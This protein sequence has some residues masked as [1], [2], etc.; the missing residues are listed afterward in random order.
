MIMDVANILVMLRG[1]ID[2]KVPLM[3]S[4]SG[5]GVRDR[6]L[7]YSMNPADRSALERALDISKTGSAKVIVCAYDAPYSEKLLREALAMGADRATLLQ[8]LSGTGS[9]AMVVAKILTRL[10]ELLKIDL[11]CTGTRLID[12]GAALEP[13]VA[14][15]LLGRCCVH[16]VVDVDIVGKTIVAVKKSDRGGRQEVQAELPAFLLFEERDESIYP[17]VA[18]LLE[19]QDQPIESLSLIDL[20]LVREMASSKMRYTV[21]AGT[22]VS[23]PRPV[24]VTTPDPALPAFERI[25]SL[26]EGGIKTR[27]GAIHSFEAEK[28]AAHLLEL[29]PAKRNEKESV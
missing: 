9:D 19:S 26:L 29:I 22:S 17:D 20:G 7:R 1:C 28:T 18:Q 11:F 23:R 16:S 4:H 27:E 24:A 3:P 5:F 2:P 13:A 14:A 10:V 25:L 8:G 12:S 15:A 21:M 6:G